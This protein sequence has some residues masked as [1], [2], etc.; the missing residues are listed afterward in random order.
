MPH[1]QHAAASMNAYGQMYMQYSSSS[2]NAGGVYVPQSHASQSRAQQQTK[3]AGIQTQAGVNRSSDA[4]TQTEL[5]GD[6]PL[7]GKIRPKS[8]SNDR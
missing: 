2:A 7:K 1:C 4:S 3:D 8:G 5:V 6:V